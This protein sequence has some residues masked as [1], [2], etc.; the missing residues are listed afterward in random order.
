MLEMHYVQF[1]GLVIVSN[2]NESMESLTLPGQ[3]MMGIF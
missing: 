1:V 2:M 3:N